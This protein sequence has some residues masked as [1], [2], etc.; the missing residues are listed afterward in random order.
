MAHLFVNLN[1]S[2]YRKWKTSFEESSQALGEAGCIGTQ[3][4]RSG[5]DPFQVFLLLEWDELERA[6]QFVQSP[7]CSDIL[8]G[9]NQAHYFM[10]E[11]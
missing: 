9:E 11:V 7:Q 10:S 4:F 8:Q 6:R 1:V 2:S 3:V 5:D